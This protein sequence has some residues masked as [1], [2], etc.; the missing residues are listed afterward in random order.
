MTVPTYG[1]GRI[2]HQILGHVWPG[3]PAQDPGS[4]MTSLENA[5]FQATLLRGAEW[6]APGEVTDG[7]PVEPT[8]R[9]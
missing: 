3:D 9:P 4:A 7:L 1:Q 5:G 6:A 2:F 8:V